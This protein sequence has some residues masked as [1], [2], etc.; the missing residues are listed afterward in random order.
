MQNLAELDRSYF[1]NIKKMFNVYQIV[2]AL[3]H[4]LR[5]T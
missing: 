2:E 4:I 1:I 5:L 3:P